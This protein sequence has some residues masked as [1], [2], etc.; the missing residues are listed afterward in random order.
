MITFKQKG[1]FEYQVLFNN[2]E[3]LNITLSQ[4]K[5]ILNNFGS[6]ISSILAM[7]E[8]IGRVFDDYIFNFL[9]G[10]QKMQV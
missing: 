7:S 9:N 4:N 3:P 10:Y 8:I 5:S 6:V 2:K 1:K